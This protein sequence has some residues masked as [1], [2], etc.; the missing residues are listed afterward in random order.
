[1]STPTAAI[2]LSH[3]QPLQQR[4][5]YCFS[6][7]Q[8]LQQALTHRSYSHTM[9][10]QQHC[11]NETLEFLGDAVLS[12]VVAHYLCEHHPHLQEG[13]LSRLRAGL[14]CQTSLYQAAHKLQ[15]GRYMR[16]SKA[17]YGS[18]AL[19]QPSTL[20]DALEAVIAAVYLDGGLGAAKQVVHCVLQIDQAAIQPSPAKDAKTQLQ[21][22]LQKTGG[23]PPFYHVVEAQGPAHQPRFTVSVSFGQQQLAQGQGSSKK[24]AQQQ[25]A[26]QA[27]QKLQQLNKQQLQHLIDQAKNDA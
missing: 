11:H 15:L 21:E 20:S 6:N 14:V 12:L 3:L 2:D 22:Q 18:A 10:Q 16:A 1:M 25:A 13:A 17:A 24:Q 9:P 27:L 19:Q 26:T 23:Q 4:L 7:P 5:G 8:L